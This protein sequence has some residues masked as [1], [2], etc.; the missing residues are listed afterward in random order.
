MIESIA[1]SVIAQ[2]NFFQSQATKPVEFRIRQLQTLRRAIYTYEKR[3]HEA[4]YLD[5]H[6]SEFESFATEIGLVL[7]EIDHHLRHLRSWVK[8][9]KVRTNQMIHFWST[10]RVYQEPYGR[11]LIMA[12]WNYPFQLLVN[13]VVGA[14]SAGNCITVK[15][16]EYAPH[17]AEVVQKMFHEFFPAEY[18]DVFLGGFEANQALLAQQWDY[19]FFTGSPAVGK[20]VMEAA[21]K[22]LT[23]VSLELGGKSPCIVDEDA[24]L[25]VAAARIVWGKLVNAGQTCIAPDYLLVHHS[26][27]ERLLEL[28]KQ[29]IRDYYGENPRQSIDY[30]RIA[31]L[32]KTER[33][34]KLIENQEVFCGG[35]FDIQER[36]FEPTIL[37]DVSPEAPIMQEEIFGP[38]LPVIEFLN[39]DE[40][41]AFVNS[42]PKPLAFYYF[43]ENK[44]KQKE[45]LSKTTSGG[46]CINDVLM[47]IANDHLPF[48]GVGNSGMGSYHGKYSFETFSHSRSILKKATWFDVPV[49]YA[50]YGS[51]IRLLKMLIK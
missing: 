5:L 44:R 46:G 8:P 27:K 35:K 29:R 3:I 43:S 25:K 19:I 16:S 15:T 24:N 6:K 2:R 28:M 20:V 45:I 4:L 30:P 21:A 42:R 38:I 40:V 12:P 1:N 22:H 26:V 47:H 49:R 51:K 7:T 10:S 50:P 33:L 36:Y 18:I 9:R 37:S 34:A 14:I 41:V 11:V 31:T 23:R 32:Q 48:G 13:P 39:L 17:T